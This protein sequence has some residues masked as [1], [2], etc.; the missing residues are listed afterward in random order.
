MFPRA[1][2]GA[3]L[4]AVVMSCVLLVGPF[5][6]VAAD[7]FDPPVFLDKWGT[8]GTGDEQFMQPMDMAVDSDGNIYVVDGINN[9]VQKFNSD[10]E[11]LLRWGTAGAGDGQFNQPM[12]IAV[13]S[14]GD[15]YV[16]DCCNHRVQ[17]FN[18]TGAY[19]T[20]WGS[21]GSGN[22]QFN[23]PDGIAVDSSDNVY[24]SDTGN[25][26]IQKFTSSGGYLA[27]LGEAGSGLGQ[28]STPEGIDVDSDGYVYVVDQGNHRVQKFD[29]EGNYELAWGQQ[30]TGDQQ[31]AAPV[32]LAVDEAAGVLYVSDIN[33]DR[34][35]KFTTGGIYL[36][37]WGEPGSG[38][39][40]FNT[41][42][43][44]DVDADGN[45]YVADRVNRRIQVFGESQDVDIDIELK[46]G[47]NMVS[48]PVD[49]G[50]TPASDVFDNPDAIYAWDPTGKS[51]TMPTTIESEKAYWVAVTED[52]TITV[53]GEPVEDWTDTIPAGWNMTGSVYGDS[54]AVADL[55]DNPSGCVQKGAIY[56][57]NPTLKCY[58][59]ATEIEQGLGYWTACTGLAELT[60]GPPLP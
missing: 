42:S 44:V 50:D 34:V 6:T 21:N 48:V 4:L 55:V 13:D 52:K 19:I 10:Y 20:K 53:T 49:T 35:Q 25:N 16:L 27:Q 60:V 45:I 2:I 31:F 23:Y 41:P 56:H 32:G 8:S 15:V 36:T 5:A 9:R 17:K 28:L 26:R 59:T 40:D 3:V 46:V 14:T 38:D 39:G 37:N 11:Y 33:I 29:S 7:P 43:G 24:V 30:G 54:V 47:W 1:R 57:W 22:D 12:S 51:Y 18:S 58:E